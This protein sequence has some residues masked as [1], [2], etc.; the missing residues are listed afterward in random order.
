MEDLF[1]LDLEREFG[2]AGY[3]F[4]FKTL[5]LIGRH[6]EAGVLTISWEN[7]LEKLRKRRPLVMKMID[8]C[9]SSGKLSATFDEQNITIECKK[10]A[11][12]SDNYTKYGMS[13]K[14]V[15]KEPLK[16]EG[17]KETDKEE[18]V[19]ISSVH[20]RWN[21]FAKQNGLTSVSKITDK[22]RTG[23]LRRTKEKQFDFEAVLAMISASPF[24]LGQNNNGWKVDF[25]FVF[26]SRDG[27]VKILEGKYNG[28]SRQPNQSAERA[29]YT[30]TDE[31]VRDDVR[32]TAESIEQMRRGGSQRP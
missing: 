14:S 19:H 17:E 6:G 4:W 25:D 30:R 3:A 16:Q 15:F 26:C 22:R 13:L 12:F 21:E 27:Y 23:I 2:D 7:Y 32:S 29:Q 8:R 31:Q 20:S 24:L 10:F 18:E 28:K 5:E 9:S 11:E 1:I